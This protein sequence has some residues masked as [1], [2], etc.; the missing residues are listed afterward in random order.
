[1][2]NIIVPNNP[3]PDKSLIISKIKKANEPIT[4]L[5]RQPL[6]Y[7]NLFLLYYK[8]ENK[9][10]ALLDNHDILSRNPKRI[11]DIINL[12]NQLIKALKT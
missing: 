10:K 3:Y 6:G 12:S 9:V 11:N 2:A 4:I 5:Y 7:V 8:E 1:M